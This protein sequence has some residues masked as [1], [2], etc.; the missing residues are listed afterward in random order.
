LEE[1]GK[2]ESGPRMVRAS[3][4]KGAYRLRR[5]RYA[6]KKVTRYSLSISM[7]LSLYV[8]FGV[9]LWRVISRLA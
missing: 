3:T 9:M 5:D 4:V 7:V 8:Y 6:K 2:A 1:V